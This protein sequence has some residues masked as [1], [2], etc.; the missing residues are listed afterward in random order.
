MAGGWRRR[1]RDSGGA[2]RGNGE[3]E[4]GGAGGGGGVH[5]QDGG[6]WWWQRRRGGGAGGSVSKAVS[7]DLQ[8]AQQSRI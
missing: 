3:A 7:E 4:Q 8:A 5:G 2:V 6:V 1:C